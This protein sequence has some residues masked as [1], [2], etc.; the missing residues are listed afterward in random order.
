MF[1]WNLSNSIEIPKIDENGVSRN[2]TNLYSHFIE[3]LWSKILK[4]PRDI[5][6]EKSRNDTVSSGPQCGH[7]Q[8][9]KWTE[10]GV[11]NGKHF[12]LAWHTRRKWSM[13]TT[14]ISVK[15]KLGIKVKKFVNYSLIGT[16]VTVAGRRPECVISNLW[17]GD[18]ILLNRSPYRPYNFLNDD[19]NL[20]TGYLSWVTFL[21]AAWPSE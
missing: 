20:S 19:S 15:V 9:P 6:G 1:C 21:K 5:E 17:E 10:P 11:W 8:D 13:E 14:C 2:T 16:E 3:L 7:T 12:L 18:F 4:V